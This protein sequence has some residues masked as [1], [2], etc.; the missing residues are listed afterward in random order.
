M[1]DSQP[2]AL[3]RVRSSINTD[4]LLLAMTLMLTQLGK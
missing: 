1:T 3:L 4:L 2:V